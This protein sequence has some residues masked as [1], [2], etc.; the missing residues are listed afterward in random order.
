MIDAENDEKN[1]DH[2]LTR[3]NRCG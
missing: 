2:K 1:K 3:A